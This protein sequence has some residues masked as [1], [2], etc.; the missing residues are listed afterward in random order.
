MMAPGTLTE[1]ELS[2]NEISRLWNLAPILS[3]ATPSTGTLHR[4]LLLSTSNA[5]YVLRAYRYAPKDRSRVV[6]EHAIASYVQSQGLPAIAPL[7][8]RSGETILEQEERLYA[9]YPYASGEQISRKQMTDP[10]IIAAMGRCLGELHQILAGYPSHQVRSQSFAVNQAATLTKIER[11]ESAIL[12]KPEPDGDSFDQHVLTALAQRKNWLLAAE[13]VDLTPFSSLL[14]QALHGDY[15]ETNLFFAQKQVSAIIDWDAAYHAPRSWELVRTLH[16]V[17]HLDVLRCLVF[18]Q[19]YQDVFPLTDE[20]LQVTA[21]AYGWVQAHNV[22][23][24]SAFYLDHNQRVRSLLQ[25]C[26]TPFAE[27]WVKLADALRA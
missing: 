1:A 5:S 8:L 23:A 15:Q 9:L 24:Y 21:Q 3:T 11:I 25:P 22:W 12:D 19:A 18:L 10:E 14:H 2:N 16:Y 17:F 20:E 13:P 26:F 4:I 27:S 7:P 6:A